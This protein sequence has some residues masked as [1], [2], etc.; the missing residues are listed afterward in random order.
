MAKRF[1]AILCIV[2][3][4]AVITVTVLFLDIF[5]TPRYELGLTVF[6]R[7][8]ILGRDG[9]SRPIDP[10]PALFP[11]GVEEGE[12]VRLC[13]RLPEQEELPGLYDDG[14]IRFYPI[15]SD[16]TLFVDGEEVFRSVDPQ[17]SYDLS[18]PVVC[19]PIQPEWAGREF[20]VLFH[21]VGSGDLQES[22]FSLTMFYGNYKTENA[23]TFAISNGIAITAGAFAIIFLLVFFFFL[24]SLFI[25]SPDWSLLVLSLMAGIATFSYLGNGLGYFFL[26]D[27][28]LS[29]IDNRWIVPLILVLVA[30]YFL[31]LFLKRRAGFWKRLGIVL[32]ACAGCLALVLL[33]VFLVN[34]TAV[35]DF[36][37]VF[38]TDLL[39]TIRGGLPPLSLDSA[40]SDDPVRGVDRVRRSAPPVL[41]AQR[42]QGHDHPP[43]PAP[44]QLPHHRAALRRN[45]HAP[46]RLE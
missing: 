10:D 20:S 24:V 16:L 11:W 1:R 7:G 19:V 35:K 41:P 27:R 18:L 22:L 2:L 14:F 21:K 3:A 6:E 34:P 29:V 43:E 39:M 46:A 13:C 17:F 9:V 44:G 8:E 37:E 30:L 25:G 38:V 31:L 42:G 28:F 23:S 45:I 33:C 4:V 32:L 36:V 26:P 12:G 5:Q 15:G 40:V